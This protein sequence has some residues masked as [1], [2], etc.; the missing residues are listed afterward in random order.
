M[1]NKINT[2]TYTLTVRNLSNRQSQK[3]VTQRGVWR[4]AGRCLVGHL[5]GIWEFCSRPSLCETPP[6]RQAP[7]TLW[8]SAAVQSGFEK[9]I[10]VT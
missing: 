1:K 8:A 3:T 9:K 10:C 6:E 4:Q 2:F 5:A 7:D